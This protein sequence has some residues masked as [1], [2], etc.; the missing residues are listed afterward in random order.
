MLGQNRRSPLRTYSLIMGAIVVVLGLVYL[1]WSTVAYG[2]FVEEK[3]LAEARTLSI[4]ASSAWD[5]INEAQ[6]AINYNADGT[7]D[8]KGV[9]CTVAGK[10]IARKFTMRSQGYE[11]SYVRDN[12]RSAHDAPDAFESQALA[13]FAGSDDSEYYAVE[14]DGESGPV[15]R[16]LVP[17]KAEFNCLQCHGEPAGEPDVTGHARE[18]MALGDL[19]GAVSISIPM[20]AYQSESQ[21]RVLQAMVFVVALLVAAIIVVRLALRRL[22]VEPLER[23]NETLHDENKMKTDF[24]DSVSHDM[25][26]PLSSIIAF[27]DLWEERLKTRDGEKTPGADDEEALMLA[28]IRANSRI[29]LNMVGNTLDA[30]RLEAGRFTFSFQELDVADVLQSVIVAI[31]PV[32]KKRDIVLTRRFDMDVP[33]VVTDETALQKIVMNL[34]GNAVKFSPDGGEVVVAMETAQG[35][36]VSIAVLDRGP[37]ISEADRRRVFERFA[38]ATDGSRG[39]SGG[40]GLGLYVSATLAEALGAKLEVSTREGGGSIFRLCVPP[41]PDRIADDGSLRS[42]AAREDAPT[43]GKDKERQ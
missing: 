27:T 17:L 32:A 38:Q 35:G 41:A 30:S 4:E 34:V 15:F 3:V 20:Q 6:D 25:R 11:I 5:Y 23:E 43:R 18:G 39:A 22:V 36:G 2:K 14:R 24:L 26:T 12:P 10:S 37:G 21:E 8:F 16:Y 29:L 1:C 13:A 33:L 31:G 28:E 19:A 7:Y 9:Y 42:G 40:V